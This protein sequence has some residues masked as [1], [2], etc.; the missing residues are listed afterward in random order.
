MLSDKKIVINPDYVCYTDFI[1]RLPDIFHTE[2]ETIYKSRNEIKV[3][4]VN[5]VKINVKQYKTPVW[6]NRIFYTF[7]RPTKAWR[8]YTYA[9]KLLAK[10]INT[11]PP[12]A[13]M[14]FKKAGLI[15]QCYFVSLQSPYTR[16]MYEFGTG[17][18]SDRAPVIRHL[19]RYA[20]KL[21][22]AGI[23]HRDFSPGN[24]LFQ[25]TEHEVNF[26]LVD[27]NRMQFGPVS[28]E[29]GCANFARLWGSKEMFTLIAKEYATARHADVDDC[30]RW[31]FDYRKRFWDR[32][33]RKRKIP[34]ELLANN[35]F[36]KI[37]VVTVV[38]NGEKLL[39][40]TICSVLCQRYPNIEYIVIDG[41][42]TDGTADI[43]RK[44]EPSLSAWISEKDNG[45]YHAMNKGAAMATGDWICFLN[46]GDVFV[47]EHTVQKAAT[48]SQDA[49]ILYGN[50]LVKAK[51]GMKERIASEP[52]NKHRMFFCHQSAFVK[53]ELA[54][55][56]PF[57]ET[58][59]M[60]ADL[61]FFKQC[62]YHGCKFYHLNFPVVIYDKSGI[63][64]TNR[65]AG[66][67]ENAK[68]VKEMDRPFQKYFFLLRLYFTVYWLKMTK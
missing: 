63:S 28:I 17:M 57:D 32:Y 56:F 67:K 51:D 15:H 49:D 22:D 30:I 65:V 21:H 7:F 43:I 61:K 59:K 44:Y 41:A 36:P 12:V 16:N 62:Y 54:R 25:Q 35:P 3:F 6:I 47:D 23:Y 37:T 2:G 26:L 53:T 55:K 64:H 60:S 68:V 58:Y 42:S 40:K 34:F 5:G 39:G 14:I 13:C 31:V 4:E 38:Y 33:A 29:K 45:I 20:A 18:L 8:A 10:E 1:N 46:C 27:I 52:C 48:E 24:I 19:A 66:L 50:I 9:L 11:P